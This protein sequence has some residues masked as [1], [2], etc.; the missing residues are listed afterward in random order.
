MSV[1]VSVCSTWQD[2]A[3]AILQNKPHRASG[4]HAAHIIEIMEAIDTSISTKQPVDIQS[5]FKQP[6][7]MD[8]AV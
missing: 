2:L 5:N 4:Q 1:L 3:E 8:W 6:E 7:M